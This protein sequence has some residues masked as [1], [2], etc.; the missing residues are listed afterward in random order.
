MKILPGIFLII[1][2]AIR[3]VGLVRKLMEYGHP[4]FNMLNSFL[5]GGIISSH[6]NYVD[7]YSGEKCKEAM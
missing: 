2:Q 3:L 7:S 5:D 4:V 1:K 6:Q